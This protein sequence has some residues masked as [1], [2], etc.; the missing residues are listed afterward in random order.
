[1]SKQTY[2]YKTIDKEEKDIMVNSFVVADS[3][4][5]NMFGLRLIK[6]RNFTNILQNDA[7]NYVINKTLASMISNGTSAI[8]KEL[9]VNTNEEYGK[10]VGVL[11]DFNFRSL[12]NAI[13]PLAIRLDYQNRNVL[14]VL[15]EINE[16]NKIETLDYIAETYSAIFSQRHLADISGNV[17]ETTKLLYTKEKILQNIFTVFSVFA[18]IVAIVGLLA[19]ANI[20]LENH[21]KEMCIRKIHGASVGDNFYR[22]ISEYFVIIGFASIVSFSIAYYGISK[23]LQNFVYQ[24]SHPFESYFYAFT[25]VVIIIVAITLIQVYKVSKIAPIKYL[26][27]NN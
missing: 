4:F 16:V 23:W 1:M 20:S 18:V 10:I 12:H 13:E 6:G 25:I 15:I 8:G 3:A 27:A 19:F 14:Y 22:F 11:D 24:I 17:S 9:S 7:D 21:L 2:Y 5:I 26:D